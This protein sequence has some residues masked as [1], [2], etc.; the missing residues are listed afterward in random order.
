MN[1]RIAGILIA[2]ITSL[3]VVFGMSGTAN[4]AG[5]RGSSG[6]GWAVQYNDH[7]MWNLKHNFTYT[8]KFVDKNARTKSTPYLKASVAYLNAMPE[9]KAAKIKF[10]LS[11]IVA[12]GTNY[13]NRNLCGNPYGTITYVLKY[14]P[15]NGKKNYSV[16]YPCYYYKDGDTARNNSAYGGYVE[17]DSEYWSNPNK[18]AAWTYGMRNIHAHE[19]GHILGLAHPD[20]AK[21]SKNE[22]TPIMHTTAGGYKN[23][24]AGKYPAPD[25][26]G[27]R[28]LVANGS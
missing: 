5:P 9:M 11:T 3:S 12:G 23:S 2:V 6:V 4:A 16:S 27:I 21:Y 7:G 14:R 28:K 8:I 24:N 15:F 1:K 18:N 20:P 13:K 10:V 17:M 25:T 22:V 19:L 26:R